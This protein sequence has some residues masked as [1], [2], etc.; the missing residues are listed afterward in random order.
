[1]NTSVLLLLQ[2]VQTIA[3]LGRVARSPVDLA[4]KIALYDAASRLMYHS[5]AFGTNPPRPLVGNIAMI[6]VYLF[7]VTYYYLQEVTQSFSTHLVGTETA[8]GATGWS[9]P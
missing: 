1:M 4:T 8:I 2:K 5:A 6:C 9:S 3:T 7:L